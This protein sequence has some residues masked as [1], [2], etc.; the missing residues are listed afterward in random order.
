MTRN[1][2]LRRL[3]AGCALVA[4]LA[5]CQVFAPLPGSE[6]GDAATY[7]HGGEGGSGSDA[8]SEAGSEASGVTQA[9]AASTTHPPAPTAHPPAPAGPCDSAGCSVH[10]AQTMDE[11]EL[12]PQYPSVDTCCTVCEA[13]PSPEQYTA[14]RA[15]QSGNPVACTDAGPLGPEQAGSGCVSGCEALCTLFATLCPVRMPDIGTCTSLCT[16][17]PTP[18]VFDACGSLNAEGSLSCRMQQIYIALEETDAHK[19]DQ[20]CRDILQ[21]RCPRRACD[22]DD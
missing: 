10:C 16:L 17:W 9:P 19:R 1:V 8:G 12:A 5:G 14:C 7:G 20:A 22:G 15:V 18:D 6:G 3:A 13:M 4:G 21:G 2:K 11:C